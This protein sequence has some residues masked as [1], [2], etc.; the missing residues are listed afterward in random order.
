MSALP[1]AKRLTVEDVVNSR[2]I[3]EPLHLHDCCVETDNTPEIGHQA[4]M[5]TP[6]A[7]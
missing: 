2:M 3:C 5:Y 4:F 7:R 6:G 1:T